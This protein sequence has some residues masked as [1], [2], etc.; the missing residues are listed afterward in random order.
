MNNDEVLNN[1]NRRDFLRILG[2]SAAA[3]IFPSIV[4]DACKK[5]IKKAVEAT[6]IIWLQGQSCS[7]CSVSLL[8][9]IDPDVPTLITKYISLNFHQTISAGT[10]EPLINVLKEAVEKKRDNY[11]LVFEG[12]ITTL[13]DEYC[14]LGIVDKHHVGIRE[15][16]LELGRNAK[17]II[18][19][20]TCAAFGGIPAARGNVTGAKSV[21]DIMQKES[22]INVPGCPSHPDW[23][24][25]TI[26]HYL[27]KGMPELDE[28]NRPKL[29]FE[30]TV[31]E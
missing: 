10:G 2:G 14:T 16:M 18:A 5:E 29:F 25:G 7:G 4:F 21:S 24:V 3:F 1:I 28:Y 31:H 12:S 19:V 15:W 9:T 13:G 27:L 26:L 17:A 22:V 8:N 11:V 30:K 20:G 6:P 23:I